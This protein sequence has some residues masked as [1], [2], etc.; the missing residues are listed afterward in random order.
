[1]PCCFKIFFTRLDSERIF[2]YSMINMNIIKFF[3]FYCV[4]KALHIAA[5]AKLSGPPETAT[6]NLLFFNFKIFF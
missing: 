1:M 2:S 5:N 3:F 4:W 6:K